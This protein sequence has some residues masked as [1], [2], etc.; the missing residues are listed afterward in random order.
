MAQFTQKAD[1]K[2]RF[3]P[4]QNSKYHQSLLL[5]LIVS[6]GVATWR[7]LNV[8]KTLN[9]TNEDLIKKVIC[10]VS[11]SLA[12]SIVA[13]SPTALAVNSDG[14]DYP[15][16]PP[17]ADGYYIAQDYGDYYGDPYYGYHLG[18]DWNGTGGGNTDYGDPVYAVSNGYVVYAR[19][20]GS[21][22]GNVIIMHH[23][24]PSGEEVRSM[25]A[26]LSGIMVNE[27]SDISKGDRIGSIGN[28]GGDYY[29]HLHF[30]IRT[31]T[32]IGLG[33]GYSDSPD[34]SGWVDPSDFI[35]NHRSLDSDVTLTLYVHEGSSDGPVISGA[36]VT[37]EDADGDS[38][39]KTTNSSGY[40]TI[41]GAPGPWNFT[42]NADGYE[43]TSWTQSITGDVTRHAYLEKNPPS[44]PEPLSPGHSGESGEEIDTLTPTLD[45]SSVE[46]ASSYEAGISVKSGSTYDLIWGD[47]TSNSQIQI[48]S[49]E[50][51]HGNQYR[52]NVQAHNDAGKSDWSSRLYFQTED[53][54]PP[55]PNPLD[56][57]TKPHVTG[58]NTIDMEATSA[59]DPEGNGVEYYF[60]ETTG[61]SGANDSN[62]R[63]SN[64]YSNSGL[65][66]GTEYCY[67]VKA[68]DKS[69]NENE[70]E[71]STTECDTTS[72]RSL[73]INQ[74]NGGEVWKVGTNH[75]IT[76]NSTN[77]GGSVKI[78]YSI[79]GRGNWKDIASS[80]NNDGAYSW[81]VPDYP[82]QNCLIKVSS[83]SYF[84]SDRSDNTF[85]IRD[86]ASINLDVPYLH[87]CCDT[88]TGFDGR[89]A[90]GATSA[91]MILK[92][93]GILDSL[94][95]DYGYYVANSYT[96]N[97]HTWNTVTNDASGDPAHGAYGYIHHNE[98]DLTDHR[99]W[100]W[101]ARNFFQD[102]GLEST[103]IENPSEQTVQDEL[104]NSFPVYVGTEYWNGHIV[105]IK[106]YNSS[107]DYYII[108]DPWPEGTYCDDCDD[109]GAERHYQWENMN[110][111]GT[112]P[113]YIVT[114]RGTKEDN[115]PPTADPESYTVP[116]DS[117]NNTLDV[118][119]NDSD[120]EGD[121]ISLDRIVSG[122]S[123]G[124]AS[125][126]NGKII[127]TPATDYTGSDSLT[128]E[129]S[130]TDNATDQ[131]NVDITI[132][133][134]TGKLSI[135]P[136]TVFVAPDETATFNVDIS[137]LTN[138]LKLLT[139]DLNLPSNLAATITHVEG[140]NI[141][142]DNGG[143]LSPLT[144][145]SDIS[146]NGKS[147][148]LSVS[149]VAQGPFTGTE[150]TVYQV[151]VK[152]LS[153]G[154][155]S[156]PISLSVNQAENKDGNDI[157]ANITAQDGSIHT[158]PPKAPGGTAK[159]NDGVD[160]PRATQN[161]LFE[162]VDGNNQF[163]I[164][165]AILLARLY[166]NLE[167]GGKDYLDEY[168]KY[169]DFDKSGDVGIDDAIRL[170]RIYVGL[171][172]G[173]A[174]IKDISKA[175]LAVPSTY[176]K[177]GSP[178][179]R[180]VKLLLKDEPQQGLKYY[181]LKVK[182]QDGP[183][184][185][186]LVG[187]KAEGLTAVGTELAQ[188]RKSVRLVGLNL[189]GR[190]K[191]EEPLTLAHLWVSEAE[192]SGLTVQI[193]ELL[194]TEDKKIS[195]PK[196]SFSIPRSKVLVLNNL[197]AYPNPTYSGTVHFRVQ[198]EGIAA[199][200][201]EVYTPKG[202]K[203]YESGYQLGKELTW[204]RTDNQDKPIPN[205][206]YLYRLKVKGLGGK[207]KY[208]ETRQLLVLN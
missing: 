41:T 176:R 86:I 16:G 88:P 181:D 53:S 201:V 21:G 192:A 114:A 111:E 101:R 204:N 20:A 180:P 129:I 194:T 10:L 62:W 202:E 149:E 27:N 17:D 84:I 193:T 40:V 163:E 73:T 187:A 38:F 80:T 58:P 170:A 59:T 184:D 153:S 148:K 139:V 106:G 39:D 77:A 123:H 60:K 136:S 177:A 150:G 121:S 35:D 13:F 5:Y 50:L 122:P 104:G 154:E 70:T 76:W 81:T 48:P 45:W 125:I 126:D 31:N 141:T 14:F 167:E 8:S 118:L 188:N 110:D 142:S 164:D 183:T 3:N 26:H 115:N 128:Y 98:S 33:P 65:E 74:P 9:F 12:L 72:N 29:A 25:Y 24:L 135:V 173:P 130:D 178:E 165:D 51:E 171:E 182:L 63:D 179:G 157:T 23:Q 37:G 137:G 119:G 117:S 95:E 4:F 67:R 133:E 127:Y 162:D 69:S 57:F 102:H 6:F 208:T 186:S 143:P 189:S 109:I 144:S 93:Y 79:N 196:L 191:D 55:N 207:V 11:L 174:S 87:Q 108:N 159:P 205:G 36:R 2:R 56:W 169:F 42:A 7:A 199:T 134:G 198:G 75:E 151:T 138:G 146:S 175:K 18:E 44:T 78:Q 145:D 34:P 1:R 200:K 160:H 132:P 107:G 68:R 89:D 61:N 124:S 172:P 85:T 195:S 46:N 92:Y 30:E 91:M 54:N 158:G 161:G 147:V 113:N 99:A 168:G 97:G 64:T 105:V 94:S 28:S 15:V 197:S 32:D 206:I 156:G 19:N 22:W 152:G 47:S 43:S 120:P 131:A 116:R 155:A 71:W 96:Y 190:D 82:S 100:A 66:T 90:C 166:V 103:Y 203:V 49:G 112:G 140:G 185:A 52:W 83:T